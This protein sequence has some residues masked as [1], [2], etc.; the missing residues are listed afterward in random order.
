[1]RAAAVNERSI[2]IHSLPN[3]ICLDLKISVSGTKIC[4][5]DSNLGSE[6]IIHCNLCKYV[7]V[8]ATSL[9]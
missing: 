2:Q 3:A 1:M 8:I 5:I 9:S 7:R 6:L 4:D